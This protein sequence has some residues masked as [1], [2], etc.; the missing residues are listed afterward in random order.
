MRKLIVLI[1]LAV[2]GGG[3]L[4]WAMG[5]AQGFIMIA[6]GNEVIQLSLWMAVVVLLALWCAL[7]LMIWVYRGLTQPGVVVWKKHKQNR[8]DKN[9]RQV[10]QG[11]ESFYEGRWQDARQSLI[12]SAPGADAP[13]LNYLVAAEAAAELGNDQEAEEILTKAEKEV[14]G[15][16]IALMLAR[17]RVLMR[18]RDY[19]RA[20]AVL[21]KAQESQ[22]KHPYVLR[23][24]KEVL[25]QQQDWESLEKLLPDLRRAK[26]EPGE[27][28]DAL[29]M[30]ARRGVL[31]HFLQADCSEDP[32]AERLG[33]LSQLWSNTPKAVRRNPE[34]L[35]LYSKALEKVGEHQRAETELRQQI[36]REW[37]GDLVLAWGNVEASDLSR[38]ITIAEAWLRSHSA[39]PELL[40]TLGRIC[41]RSELWGKA[42]DYLERAVAVTSSPQAYGELAI[43]MEQLGERRKSDEYYQA[44]LKSSLELV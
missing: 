9:R 27:S 20:A 12:K 35:A 36:N 22:P 5:Y 18:G 10:W 21:H 33:K 29:E 43:V 28:L 24:L 26:A 15:D 44:G 19:G 13:A 6:V 31:N 32:L 38:Q 4:F 25:V 41:R 2:A 3:L 8:A 39:S 14:G 7:R 17:A 42:K 16:S 37:N 30:S 1:A 40:L 34:V 23:L 11:L